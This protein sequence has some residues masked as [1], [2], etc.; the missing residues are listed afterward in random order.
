MYL[1]I[2]DRHQLAMEEADPHISERARRRALVNDLMR[3]R[4]YWRV[5]NWLTGRAVHCGLPAHR[6]IP[7]FWSLSE[8]TEFFRA[9]LRKARAD[10]V[11]VEHIKMALVAA[12]YFQ[13]QR[14]AWL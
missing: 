5:I 3:D 8:A 13:Q 1:S 2:D 12:R 6:Y 9:A 14:G 4:S 7:G 10:D 11:G